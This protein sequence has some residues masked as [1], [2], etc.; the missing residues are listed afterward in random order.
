MRASQPPEILPEAQANDSREE[1][2]GSSH[3]ECEAP[4]GCCMSPSVAPSLR[5]CSDGVDLICI[6][7]TFDW[8]KVVGDPM[9]VLL[10]AI[11]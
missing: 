7:S 1:P 9:S 6:E 3:A 2:L 5:S 11:T 4:S 8:T 10:Y